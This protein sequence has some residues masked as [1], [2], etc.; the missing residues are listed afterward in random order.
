MS[1]VR[2]P[3]TACSHCGKPIYRRP[4]ELTKYKHVYC[5]KRCYSDAL[6]P[7]STCE[8][9][10]ISFKPKRS[11]GRY[12]S[13]ECS[14]RARTGTSRNP[15]G[16]KQKLEL[17]HREFDFDTCMV[18]GCSY[19]VTLDVHRHIPGCDGGK[20]EVGNMFALCPNHHAEITRGLVT[21]VKVNDWTLRRD[22]RADDCA[23]LEA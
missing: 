7:I 3:N 10:G 12:C 15:V 2:H 11:R 23:T 17:L 18:E 14:N 13:I 21:M 20:Y 4:K 16:R 5:T 22:D 8:Q 1:Q 9:C 19:G 6:K